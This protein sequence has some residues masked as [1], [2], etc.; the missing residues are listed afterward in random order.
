MDGLRR[1]GPKLEPAPWDDP[2]L[3]KTKLPWEPVDVP[4][5]IRVF[6]QAGPTAYYAGGDGKL[7]SIDAAT[8]KPGPSCELG[9][10]PSY[11][12]LAAAQGRLYIA[13]QDGRVVCLGKR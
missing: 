8:G 7:Q 5:D 10:A 11:D 2:T 3:A 12:G 6:I 13:L 4:K 9:A 1:T